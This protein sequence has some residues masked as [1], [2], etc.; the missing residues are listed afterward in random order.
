MMLSPTTGGQS[1]DIASKAV[2]AHH[3]YP[4]LVIPVDS[5]PHRHGVGANSSGQEYQGNAKQDD[6]E[7]SPILVTSS[8]K[9][10]A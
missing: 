7:H 2:L 9:R 8:P 4:A 3:Q 6:F 10:Q 1:L 5:R